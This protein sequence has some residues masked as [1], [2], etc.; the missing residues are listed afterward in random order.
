MVVTGCTW[1]LRVLLPA[2]FWGAKIAMYSFYGT[3]LCESV[4]TTPN[5]WKLNYFLKPQDSFGEF[6]TFFLDLQ[7]VQE[8][9]TKTPPDIHAIILNDIL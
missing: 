5:S 6:H 4:T 2:L 7:K 8:I 1:L 9:R 3:V